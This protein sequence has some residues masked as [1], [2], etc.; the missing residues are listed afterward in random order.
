MDFRTIIAKRREGMVHSKEELTFLAEG[1]AKGDIPDYQ[2]SA[3]LMAAYL[4]P[5]TDQETVDLTIAMA[6]SGDRLDLTG[7]PKPWVDKH[8]TGGVGDKTTLVLGPLLAA[9]G[10]SVIKMSGRGLGIT[11]GTIDKLKAI[12]GFSSDL[13]PKKMV[14]QA[15]KIGIAV[16]GQTSHLAPAD[17]ALYALRDVTETVSSIPLIVSSILSKKVA[18]GAETVILDVKCGS[19]SFNPT[20]EQAEKLADALVAVGKLAGLRAF[21]AITDMDQPL[22]SAVGNALEVKEA[23]D[24]LT[25]PESDLSPNTRRFRELCRYYGALAL[26]VSGIAAT[27][28]EALERIEDTLQ[29]GRALDK[30]N[31]WIKAQGATVD[32]ND[33]SW[34]VLAPIQIELNAKTAGC[35]GKVDARTI[36]EIALDLGAG[37]RKKDDEI[38]LSVGLV[39]NVKVGDMIS[40]NHLLATVHAA[41]QEAASAAI[42]RLEHS[43]QIQTAPIPPRPIL[44]R[45]A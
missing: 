40:E 19:G 20:R 41:T 35:I 16:A 29:S 27:A 39:V 9:C 3:W 43:I 30:A 6:D 24:V 17:K 12:P 1:A 11:G 32:F 2:L 44:I 5:L 45:P 23:I 15:K 33:T 10:L 25:K 38:D 8:S 36:G 28:G 13:T 34:L 26:R 37:R 31:Q 4:K 18:G 21:A 14:A 42:A 7:V 22:G